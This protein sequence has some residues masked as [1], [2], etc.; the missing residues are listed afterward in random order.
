MQRAE[1]RSEGANDVD[2]WVQVIDRFEK[3]RTDLTRVEGLAEA[4]VDVGDLIVVEKG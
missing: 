2:E 4:D 1:S 3:L